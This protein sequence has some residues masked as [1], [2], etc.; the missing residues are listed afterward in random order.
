MFFWGGTRTQYIGPPVWVSPQG[1][2]VGV[3][4]RDDEQ[5]VVKLIHLLEQVQGVFHRVVHRYSLGKGLSGLFMT[6]WT[7]ARNV[8]SIHES[9]LHLNSMMSH[10]NLPRFHKEEEPIV[11]L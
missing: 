6:D 11:A 2:D 3:V 10:V 8:L 1:H 4:G 7:K 5:G 9:I